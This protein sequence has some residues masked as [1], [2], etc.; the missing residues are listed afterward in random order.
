LGERDVI[1]LDGSTGQVYKW[2]LE[3]E[4]AS[5]EVAGFDW[6]RIKV[7]VT[8]PTVSAEEPAEAATVS[9][10]P[11][12]VWKF[13]KPGGEQASFVVELSDQPAP[14]K[15]SMRIGPF[16]S[17]EER[18]AVRATRLNRGQKWSWR[19][20]ALDKYGNEGVSEWRTFRTAQDWKYSPP[21]ATCAR[22][23]EL[24][25]SSGAAVAKLKKGDVL[26]VTGEGDE[27]LIVQ[28]ARGQEGFVRR[29]DVTL[30][31]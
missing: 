29:E 15:A 16:D 28:T 25:S 26:A 18:F 21:S 23:C 24:R 14:K 5:G 9:G 3:A 2:K 7:D 13:A 6:Q 12:L 22:A 10:A 8:A 20:R 4:L 27:R 19:V 11:D 1:T 30:G 31:K 17:K